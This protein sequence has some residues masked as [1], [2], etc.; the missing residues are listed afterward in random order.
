MTEE[1]NTNP[2]LERVKLP[3]ETYTLPSQGLFYTHGELDESVNNGEVLIYPMN[4]MDELTL[5]TPDKLFSGEAITDVF[6]RCVPQIKQPMQLLAK[7][8]DFIMVCLRK[9]TYGEFID[10]KY[11][12][13]CTD[14]KEHPY[15]ISVDPFINQTKRIDP[16]TITTNYTLKLDN[17][18]TLK[19]APPRIDVVLKIYQSTNDEDEAKMSEGLFDTI[20]GMVE[21]VDDITDEKMIR[22]WVQT[23]PAGWVHQISDK[24]EDLSDWGPEFASTVK[25]TDCGNNMTV[26]TP[27]NPLAF[28]I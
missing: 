25:C 22:E 10:I 19:L 17:G 24:V 12:H 21:S 2:L 13:N 3:G 6:R 15:S 7:D 18:Q 16:T 23:I 11:Q 8:V 14:S 27:I 4:T 9:L 20:T 1:T 5:K 26:T 28:F